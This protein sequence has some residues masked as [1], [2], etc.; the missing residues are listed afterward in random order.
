MRNSSAWPPASKKKRDSADVTTGDPRGRLTRCAWILADEG[1]E[2]GLAG[3]LTARGPMP[4]T[5]WTLPL[6]LAFD[7][8]GEAVWLLIGDDLRVIE[9]EGA[10]GVREPNPATRFHLWI[11]R[12][13]P[14]VHAI[15]HTHP[16][17]ASALAAAE[18]PLVVAHMDSTPL[19][20]D[21][22]FLPRWPGL[23]TADREGEIISAGLGDKHAILLAHHGILAAGRSVQEAAFLAVF[24]ERAARQQLD[25]AKVGGAKPVDAAEAARARDFLRSERIM[26]MTFD[27]WARRAERRR[28][29]GAR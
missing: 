25:A 18:Q 3:Q 5:V 14:D 20:D 2:S 24:M 12:A 22:A 26:N 4:G 11:Y 28:M 16:P 1:H 13:R 27:A 23:P 7:E 8:A 21:V 29:E 10:F 6:G 15:V 9:G 17:A 19:H